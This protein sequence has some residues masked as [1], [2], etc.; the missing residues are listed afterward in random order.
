MW[1]DLIFLNKSKYEIMGY[2]VIWLIKEYNRFKEEMLFMSRPSK[3]NDF[4]F[5]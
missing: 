3:W 4:S 1:Y 5:L 2:D